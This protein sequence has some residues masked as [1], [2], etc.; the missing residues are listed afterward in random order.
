MGEFELE[1][2]ADGIWLNT[3]GESE[4]LGTF[5]EELPSFVRVWREKPASV[6]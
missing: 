4:E 1:F 3:V 6:G 2:E 5:D